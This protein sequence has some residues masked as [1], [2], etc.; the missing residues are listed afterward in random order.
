MNLKSFPKK[1]KNI[2]KIRIFY[3]LLFFDF[4]TIEQKITQKI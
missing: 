1:K 2:Y 4:K 3:Y